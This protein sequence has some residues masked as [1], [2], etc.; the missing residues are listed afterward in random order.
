MEIAL[1]LIIVAIIYIVYKGYHNGTNYQVTE[2]RKL[3]SV[4]NEVKSAIKAL[5]SDEL[6]YLRLNILRLFQRENEEEY[7][8]IYLVNPVY[9]FIFK[10]IFVF[11]SYYSKKDVSGTY[12]SE[13]RVLS[14]RLIF[15]PFNNISKIKY[16]KIDSKNYQIFI[17]K[18]EDNLEIVLTFTI[19]TESNDFKHLIE[20]LGSKL[21]IEKINNDNINFYKKL[22]STPIYDDE[23]E[24]SM[25]TPD[26][27]DYIYTLK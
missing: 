27:E 21:L 10:E 15:L 22:A 9:I 12:L 16:Y 14:H 8:R 6:I 23:T 26:I 2:K 19:Q 3:E 5:Y 7:E 11:R 18:P 17:I 24:V 4:K 20:Y 1:L 13:E 25:Y